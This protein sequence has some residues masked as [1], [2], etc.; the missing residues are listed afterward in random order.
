MAITTGHEFGRYSIEKALGSGGM[1]SVFLAR[2]TTLRRPVA[3]KTTM[4]GATAGTKTLERFY[5]E[6][7]AAA[8]FRHPNLCKVHDVGEIDGVHYLTMEYIEGRPLSDLLRPGDPSPTIE[9]ALAIARGAAAGLAEAHR[10]GVIHR[11]MKPSNIMIEADGNP[12]IVDFGLARSD[13]E[14][15]SSLTES[16]VFLGT[17][18]YASPE[19]WGED[20]AMVGPESDIYSLGVILYQMLCGQLPFSGPTMSALMNRVLSATPDPPSARRTGLD[21]RLDAI[22]LRAIAKSPADRFPSMSAFAQGLESAL[23][24]IRKFAGA[25]AED[26]SRAQQSATI[27]WQSP[28][29]SSRAQISPGYA[30]TD[31]AGPS[32][33]AA[34]VCEGSQAR[35]PPSKRPL[36]EFDTFAP[37]APPRSAGRGR[38]WPVLAAAACLALL[39]MGAW[40]ALASRKRHDTSDPPSTD[41]GIANPEFP[42]AGNDAGIR[43]IPRTS[44]DGKSVADA[45][46]VSSAE[47]DGRTRPKAPPTLVPPCDAKVTTKR[48]MILDVVRLSAFDDS[49]RAEPVR[50]GQKVQLIEISAD[51]RSYL[52]Q[53]TAG[54]ELGWIPK[55]YLVPATS[56]DEP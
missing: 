54:T 41:A 15:E 42:K 28:R 13:M 49:K 11:D 7:R 31:A 40:F 20:P 3:L 14:G 10:F 25:Q 44:G 47:D 50:A 43:G 21:H 8:G 53:D 23:G 24:D 39:A 46:Y 9:T 1:G 19:Q 2:D 35:V 26:P 6:A 12:V 52:A 38:L 27:E 34:T 29:P 45:Q 51:G 22:C 33:I 17:R 36:A 32:T 4:D 56:P 37:Y 48:D 18:T 16:G 55:Q 30:P 5:R